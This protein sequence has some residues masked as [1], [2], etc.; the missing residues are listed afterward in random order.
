LT[1][2]NVE[3]F[4]YAVDNSGQLLAYSDD[5]QAGNVSDPTVVGYGAWLEFKFLFAGQ[6]AVGTNCIY[7]VPA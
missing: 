3:N 1:I 6:N 5:G 7:A 4:I 2:G